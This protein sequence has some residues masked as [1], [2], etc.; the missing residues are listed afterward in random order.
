MN[1][2]AAATG[3]MLGLMAGVTLATAGTAVAQETPT[4]TVDEVVVT[5]FRSSPQLRR[6]VLSARPR[7]LAVDARLHG[8]PVGA[9][10]RA[11]RPARVPPKRERG[12]RAWS[13]VAAHDVHEQ[14]VVPQLLP[15]A[16]GHE[17]ADRGGGDLG[18]G[19]DRGAL[20]AHGAERRHFHLQ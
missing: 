7:Q 4:T 18:S 19:G 9:E 6:L 8:A 2:M 13:R 10:A 20:V 17:Q 3:I 15:V 14:L 5:G 1:R 16:A 12:A 11:A